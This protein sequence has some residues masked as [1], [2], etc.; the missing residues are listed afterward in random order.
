MIK[1]V[2]TKPNLVEKTE[3]NLKRAENELQKDFKKKS[4]FRFSSTKYLYIYIIFSTP[5]IENFIIT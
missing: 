5:L 2:A 4:N 3:L 1:D